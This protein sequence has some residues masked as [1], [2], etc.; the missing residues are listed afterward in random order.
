MI[1]E[2]RSLRHALRVLD[3][4]DQAHPGDLRARW[5]LVRAVYKASD[6]LIH[7]LRSHHGQPEDFWHGLPAEL[8][9]FVSRLP[10][11]TATTQEYRA[12]RVVVQTEAD[13]L[14]AVTSCLDGAWSG[15]C[16]EVA[17]DRVYWL[18]VALPDHVAEAAMRSI[19]AT[20]QATQGKP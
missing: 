5:P 13:A 6:A 8:Q 11:P 14:I 12:S 20:L 15:T 1:A 16:M 3:A 9:E 7:Y 4:H 2:L 17:C 18:E 10:L 19:Q